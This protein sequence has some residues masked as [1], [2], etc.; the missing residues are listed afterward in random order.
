MVDGAEEVLLWHIEIIENQFASVRATHTE[1]IKFTGTR[2]TGRGLIDNERCDAFGAFCRLGLCV[3]NDVVCIW[4]LMYEYFST[5]R[6]KVPCTLP[7]LVIHI[8][9]PFKIQPSS[10][11]LA[12]VF[13]LTTSDPA[14]CSDMASAPIFVPDIKPGRKRSFWSE[15]PFKQS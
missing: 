8:L 2:E 5:W 14:E 1:L 13:I 11:G 3:H 15:V 6:S 4:T 10:T 7:T 9:V 12:V